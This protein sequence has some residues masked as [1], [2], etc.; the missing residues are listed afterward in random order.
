MASSVGL[1]HSSTTRPEGQ[2]QQREALDVE[3]QSGRGDAEVGAAM[4]ALQPIAQS[5]AV[6]L[7]HE[8]LDGQAGVGKG[9]PQRLVERAQA[10][11]ALA[12]PPG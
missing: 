1:C 2:A 11:E 12:R 8:I 5:S 4:G 7:D 3:P 9:F 6:A 10:V